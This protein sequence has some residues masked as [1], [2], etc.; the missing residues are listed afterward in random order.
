MAQIRRATAE[1]ARGIAEVHVAS[2]LAA[3]SG[4]LP[5]QK[6]AQL[7]VDEREAAWRERLTDAEGS[8]R[9]AWVAI[10]KDGIVGFAFAQPSADEDVGHGVHELTALYLV[11]SAWR[12]EIGT[13]L[14]SV[15]DA[16]LRDTHVVA[17]TLWVL[18]AND[19]ARS[20]YEASGWELDGRDPS[21]K[22][23]GAPA[24][25]YRKRL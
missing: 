1:D 7:D 25:R 11:P 12:R 13:A 6:L 8:E 21:F 5:E 14:L 2:W 10:E 19:A 18:E 20:F 4:V 9:R 3:Y 16:A 23:F 17:A 24:L 15:A 22:D